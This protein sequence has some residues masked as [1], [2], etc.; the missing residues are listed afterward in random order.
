MGYFAALRA[1]KTPVLPSRIR[2]GLSLARSS[3]YL[4]LYRRI[5]KILQSLKRLGIEE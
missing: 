3:L 4:R 5:L 1:E 2:D